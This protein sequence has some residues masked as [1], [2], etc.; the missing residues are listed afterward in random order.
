MRDKYL[1]IRLYNNERYF[2]NRIWTLEIRFLTI[3]YYILI[4]W[5][6]KNFI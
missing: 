4:D 3:E 1:I 5:E 6:I 2:N